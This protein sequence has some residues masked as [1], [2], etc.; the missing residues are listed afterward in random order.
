VDAPELEGRAFGASVGDWPAFPDSSAA[1]RNLNRHYP[2]VMLSNV[3][4]ASFE[5]SARRLGIEFDHVFTAQDIGSYKPAIRNFEYLIDRLDHEGYRREEI[6]HTAQ[7]L[8]HDHIPANAV[9]LAS[10]WINRQAGHAGATPSPTVE[11]HFDF[12]FPTLAAM[13]RAVEQLS[14]E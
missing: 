1:L 9:G 7:S 2:L 6:L 13:A 5:C 4:H 8:F 3:D 10:A 12:E 14:D 11:P